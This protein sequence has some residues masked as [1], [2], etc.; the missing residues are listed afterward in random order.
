MY[1]SLVSAPVLDSNAASDPFKMAL[2]H[3]P[4]GLIKK[5]LPQ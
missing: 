3:G 4:D 5:C 1:A 2:R